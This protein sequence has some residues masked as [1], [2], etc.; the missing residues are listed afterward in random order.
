MVGTFSDTVWFLAQQRG[1][2]REGVDLGH[3]SQ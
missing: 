1:D 2:E 3:G